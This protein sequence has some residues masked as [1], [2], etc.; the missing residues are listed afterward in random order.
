[1]TCDQVVV[2]VRVRACLGTGWSQ[3]RQAEPCSIITELARLPKQQ[4]V[5]GKHFN[6][7][8]P[9]LISH[10]SCPPSLSA[11]GLDHQVTSAFVSQCCTLIGY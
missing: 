9:S 6:V 10:A 1:M 3:R 2:D 4:S 7:T 8:Y 11:L 5:D